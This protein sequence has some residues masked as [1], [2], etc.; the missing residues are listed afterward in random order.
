[1]PGRT[2]AIGDIHGYLRA[3]RALWK[4]IDPQPDDLIVTMGDYVDRGPDS[5]GVVQQLIEWKRDFQVVPLL[6]NHDEVMLD[7]C[8]G[9]L[10]LLAQWPLFGGDTTINSYG[11]VPERVP[12]DH[13][14]FLC[15]CQP[16]YET[17][18]HLFVHANYRSELPLD[19]QPD[20]VLRWESLRDRLPGPHCSGKTAILGHTAQKDGKILDLG[21][22]KCIDTCL[23]GDGWLTALE[24]ETGQVWQVDQR[25]ALR[26]RWG[27]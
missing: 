1:M 14:A 19:R 13:V 3:V 16:F 5:H 21:Y 22:L 10:G 18:R 17:E 15:D 2:I 20:T 24:A 27:E 11:G 26:G 7:I 9:R 8:R 23:Y 4:A 12:Q 6:G 25:G